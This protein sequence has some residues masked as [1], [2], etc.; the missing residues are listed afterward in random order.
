[1]VVWQ[2]GTPGRPSDWQAPRNWDVGRV[3]GETDHVIIPAAS[4]NPL[5]Q[6]VI[7]HTAEVAW[8]EI[9]AGATLTVAATGILVVSGDQVYSEGISIYGGEL[10]A[11]GEIILEKIDVDWLEGFQP[12][13]LEE[14]TTYYSTNYDFE[15]SVVRQ[16]GAVKPE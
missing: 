11:E 10:I 3:P 7:E 6:P 13:V 5:S 8:V 12:V 14:R 9:H 15:F 16:P 1:M 4:Y 2:G